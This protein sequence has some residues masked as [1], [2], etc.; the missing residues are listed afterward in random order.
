MFAASTTDRFRFLRSLT[1]WETQDSSFSDDEDY[2]TQ[3]KIL[4]ILSRS[5]HLEKVALWN[6]ESL[7]DDFPG[8]RYL[9]TD[10]SQAALQEQGR[11]DFRD[12]VD[13]LGRLKALFT[14]LDG[15]DPPVSLFATI[16]Q[17]R[18]ILHTISAGYPCLDAID[19]GIQ[20]HHIDRLDIGPFALSVPSSCF[21][22][23]TI[24]RLLPNLKYL[25]F[26]DDSFDGDQMYTLQRDIGRRHEEH[27][28]EAARDGVADKV[29]EEFDGCADDLY[30]GAYIC[31]I[32]KLVLH[33]LDDMSTPWL[34]PLLIHVQPSI[35][36]LEFRFCDSGPATI[37]MIASILQ[38]LSSCN[39]LQHLTLICNAENTEN[40][41]ILNVLER[42]PEMLRLTSITEFNFAYSFA[43]TAQEDV[44]FFNHVMVDWEDVATQIILAVPSI[45]S[46]EFDSRW[47]AEGFTKIFRIPKN[48]I[49]RARQNFQDEAAATSDVRSNVRSRNHL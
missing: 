36:S 35:L 7:L 8:A 15:I 42:L 6:V 1:I 38:E 37:G 44:A 48:L 49:N 47:D 22:A 11:S 14:I 17:F 41:V 19:A 3:L 28:M 12:V 32:N 5:T 27:M 34:L 21:S 39:T 2:R 16:L 29:L 31:R 4:R 10:V 24:F 23:S 18:D 46:M 25:A 45:I 43:L 30:R 13:H 40:G 26:P 33:Y 9:R 20:F